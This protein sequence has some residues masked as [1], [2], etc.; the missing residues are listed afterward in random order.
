[1]RSRTS[2]GA[3]A[4]PQQA[5]DRRIKPV[6]SSVP[7]PDA[8]THPKRTRVHACV[9]LRKYALD[10]VVGVNARVWRLPLTSRAGIKSVAQ[11]VADEVDGEHREK[12]RRAGEQRPMRGDVERI[13]GIKENAPPSGNVG[14]EAEAEKRQGRFGNDGGGNVDRAGNDYR[15]ERIRQDVPHYQA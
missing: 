10:R 5:D 7:Q 1:M 11:S 13:L 15:S 8:C 4:A 3:S 9:Q 12:N 2:Q 14:R 6:V